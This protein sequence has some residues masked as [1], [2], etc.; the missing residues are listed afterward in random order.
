MEALCRDAAV[1]CRRDEQQGSPRSAGCRLENVLQ[2]KL[3]E[4]GVGGVV[5]EEFRACDLSAVRTVVRD[6]RI[7]PGGMIEKV[8]AVC[9]EL[10]ILFTPGGEVLEERGVYAVVAGTVER[11]RSAAQKGD[12]RS[13][14]GDRGCVLIA[15][16]ISRRNTRRRNQSPGQWIC[17]GAGVVPVR[18]SPGLRRAGDS[19]VGGVRCASGSKRIADSDGPRTAAGRGA[20]VR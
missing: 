5:L 4:P 7:R 14:V 16:V 11:V 6:G 10:Q 3:E 18:S 13:G 1:E 2:R 15:V 9:T 17:E 8:E 20:D 12:R 19:R